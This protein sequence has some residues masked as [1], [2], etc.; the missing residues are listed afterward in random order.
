MAAATPVTPAPAPT[1]IATEMGPDAAP[2]VQ[3]PDVGTS[4][5]DPEPVVP[6]DAGVDS[7]PPVADAEVVPPDLAANTAP[8]DAGV[9]GHRVALVV[10]DPTTLAAGDARLRLFFAAKGFVVQV[11]PD[12]AGAAEVATASLVVISSSVRPGV[13]IDRMRNVPQPVMLMKVALF[14]KLGMTGATRDLD[15][16]EAT[17]TELDVLAAGHPL[18]AGLRGPVRVAVQP[19]ALAWARPSPA[20]LR[21]AGLPG[22]PSKLGIFAYERGANMVGHIAPGRRI[23]F[24]ATERLAAQ[25]TTDAVRLLDAAVA[26]ATH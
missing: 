10:S 11:L 15:N 6:A 5:I 23:G 8:A 22:D 12:S 4:S 7:D 21:I 3:A 18:S 2:D 25:A 24:F 17:G 16:G 26:W 9:T 20:A 14:D 13:Q 19:A 1:E